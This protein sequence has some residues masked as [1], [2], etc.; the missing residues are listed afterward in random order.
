MAAPFRRGRCYSIEACRLLRR[1]SREWIG[2]HFDYVTIDRSSPIPLH[3]QLED[4]I[5][6]AIGSGALKV[7]DKLP[8]EDDL[9]T[10]FGLSRPVVRQAYGSLVGAGLLVRE[11]GRGSFVKAQ[12][13]GMF[14]HKILSFSQEML[15]LGHSPATRVLS[16]CHAPLPEYAAGERCPAGGDWLY[17]ERLR[18]T[19]GTPSVYLRTWV[20][21]DRFP[22]IEGYDF[23]TNSL[24]S[25][26]KL[27]YDVRPAHADRSVWAVNADEHQSDLLSLPLGTA[28]E[29]MHSFVE[30]QHN[31]LMEISI[32]YFPGKSCRF[33]FSV[34]AE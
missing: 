26:I 4:S 8:T 33:N 31:E 13:Y 5:T 12:N 30:D 16:F 15:L 20:P 22:A 18:Y 25:T 9:A 1:S 2:M 23:S 17:L 10:E 21:A 14:A 19:D 3:K 6:R 32:E 29:V 27:L 28:L 34:D 24:Y 11:R 7:G